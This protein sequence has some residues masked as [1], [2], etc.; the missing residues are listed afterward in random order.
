MELNNNSTFYEGGPISTL[1]YRP[2]AKEIYYRV[3]HFHRQSSTTWKSAKRLQ[4]S[5]MCYS[6]RAQRS[7]SHLRRRHCQFFSFFFCRQYL[8]DRPYTQKNFSITKLLRMCKFLLLLQKTKE[9]QK[10][11][12]FSIFHY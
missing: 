3:V 10:I 1:P 12:A 7:G 4:D 11:M 8:S 2:T 9:L 6:G 5:T